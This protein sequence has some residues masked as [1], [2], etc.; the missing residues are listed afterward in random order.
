[1]HQY[2]KCQSH[3]YIIIMYFLRVWPTTVTLYSH[4][5][6]IPDVGTFTQLGFKKKHDSREHRFSPS[7]YQILSPNLRLAK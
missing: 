4:S 7:G 6:R 2:S 5:V 3:G 1:M